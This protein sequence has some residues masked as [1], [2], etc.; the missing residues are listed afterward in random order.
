MA[1]ISPEIKCGE[2]V[3]HQGRA[4]NHRI[5]ASEVQ[6]RLGTLAVAGKLSV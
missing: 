2:S 6:E 5:I 3:L 4:D 1:M